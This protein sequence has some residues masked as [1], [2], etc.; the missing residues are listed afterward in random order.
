MVSYSYISFLNNS[1]IANEMWPSFYLGNE[2]LFTCVGMFHV[3]TSSCTTWFHILWEI[4]PESS[5]STQK[6]ILDLPSDPGS[7][8]P[9]TTFHGIWLSRIYTF[10]SFALH[11]ISCS[12]RRTTRGRAGFPRK[13]IQHSWKNKAIKPWWSVLKAL[14]WSKPVQRMVW[15]KYWEVSTCFSFCM[16]SV[17]GGWGGGCF[18]ICCSRLKNMIL[19]P[20]CKT[21]KL[22]NNDQKHVHEKFV[23]EGFGLGRPRVL[24]S[25]Q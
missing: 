5:R 12:S 8:H 18:S 7:S 14:T 9:S 17:A 22:N 11:R 19:G 25:D 15:R 21:S 23:K 13:S 6:L 1:L 16:N 24:W 4:R 20:R 10:F 2:F 3:R